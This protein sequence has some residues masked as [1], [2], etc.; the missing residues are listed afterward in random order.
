MI[1]HYLTLLLGM[2]AIAIMLAGG[3]GLSACALSPQQVALTPALSSLAV[4][5][6]QGRTLA[7]VVKDQRDTPVV[8][9]RGGLY[10]GTS[11][12]TLSGDVPAL[13]QDQLA[14]LFQARGF[15]MDD[16]A[17]LQLELYLDELIYRVEKQEVLQQVR[18]VASISVKAVTEYA[19]FNNRFRA[20]KIE[21][22]LRYPSEE[23]NAAWLNDV[24]QTALTR[25]LTD[26]GLLAFI[27]RHG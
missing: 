16:Q 11:H 8:G 26:Q 19:T 24:V 7:I 27:A 25:A 6:G 2:R 5:S 23:Q 10:S 13:L 18:I 12:I 20:Q 17:G 15:V 4:G 1:K 14:K 22:V 3:L 9:D 21:Q